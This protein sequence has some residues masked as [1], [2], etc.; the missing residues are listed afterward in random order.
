MFN[1]AAPNENEIFM[2]FKI[3]LTPDK[4]VFGYALPI[5]YQYELSSFIYHT[6]ACANAEYST[7]LHENGFVT[8]TKRFKLFSFSNLIFPAYKI[9]SDR[10]EILSERVAFIVSFLPERSTE[11]FIRGLFSEQTFCLG[12]KNSKVQFSVSGIEL[13]PQPDFSIAHEYTTL[14]PVCITHRVADSDRVIYEAPDSGYAREALLMNLKNKYAAF[15]GKPYEGSDEFVFELLAPP[16]SKLIAIKTN[17]LQQTKVKGYM[18]NFRL[19]ASHQLMEVMYNAG[20]GEKGSLGCGDII[21]SK[22]LKKIND[23]I[24]TR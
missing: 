13:L 1:I 20:L 7:W 23:S 9:V 2:R 22:E 18:F 10:I 5:N 17:T 8:D 4:R 6:L 21:I 11:E 15:T 14:S 12:D 24:R 19:R 16:R 3:T